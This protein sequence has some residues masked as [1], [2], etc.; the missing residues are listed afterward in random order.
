M[1]RQGQIEGKMGIQWWYFMVFPFLA[2]FRMA[3]II[4]RLIHS[5]SIYGYATYA[6]IIFNIFWCLCK[7][8]Y[9]W[10]NW[11][12]TLYVL[13]MTKVIGNAIYPFYETCLKYLDTNAVL[14]IRR[15][16][17]RS[18]TKANKLKE[19]CQNHKKT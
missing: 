10:T 2:M 18:T 11:W 9:K 5:T 16:R 13:W 7:Q 12:M 8:S 17:S 19:W 3:Q 1:K 15:K 14:S 6:R 4:F